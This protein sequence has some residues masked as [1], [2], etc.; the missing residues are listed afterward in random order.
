MSGFQNDIDTL[1]LDQI[2]VGDR[3]RPVNPVAVAALKES[4]AKIG[5]KTPISVRFISNE[6]GFQ[7]ITGL[8]RYTAA[9]ELGWNRIAVRY[10]TGTERDAL[11]WEIAEN[12]HRAE[13]TELERSNH[14][15]EWIRLAEED[16]KEPESVLAQLGPKL[17]A[18]GREH[19]GRPASGVRAAARDL[20][21]ER[22]HAQR[23]V[24]IAAIA[25][26]AKE[27]A[28]E[29]GLDDNQSA[30][31]KA[32]REPEPAA[33]VASLHAHALKSLH[34]EPEAV[35]LSAV[36]PAQNIEAGMVDQSTVTPA[37]RDFMETDE[38]SPR[39]AEQEPEPTEAQPQPIEAEPTVEPVLAKPVE[40]KP[41]RLLDDMPHVE[42]L[43]VILE[44]LKKHDDWALAVPV[45]D[46]ADYADKILWAI[47]VS[48]SDAQKSR[49]G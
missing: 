5:M 9:G 28:R 8:N 31:L 38:L 15:A 37:R 36:K 29:L 22:H 2:F 1:S 20:G 19:E 4:F 27:A 32:A 3:L 48:P 41:P 49:G 39:P 26:A 34:V 10:E 21:I 16:R 17:S 43:D 44:A 11:Q 45:A 35:N 42:L 47:G 12:L 14:I 40:A 33:Q 6:L 13:L 30:L 46:R 7:L 18:R 23:S 24:K 25:P